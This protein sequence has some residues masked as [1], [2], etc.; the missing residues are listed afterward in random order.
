MNKGEDFQC[1]CR[2]EIEATLPHSSTI[3]IT[4]TEIAAAGK[5]AVRPVME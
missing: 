1:Q 5:I 4:I 3:P 2:K